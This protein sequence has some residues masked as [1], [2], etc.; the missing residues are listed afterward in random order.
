MYEIKVS[1]DKERYDSKPTGN[2]AAKINC[3]IGNSVEILK[4]PISVYEF[5]QRVGQCGH[6]FS[7][8]TFSNG[9]KNR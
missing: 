5:V 7:P 1:L 8:A 3:R 6:T 2:E 4:C 9:A